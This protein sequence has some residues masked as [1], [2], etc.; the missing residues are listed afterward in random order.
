MW[1]SSF[2]GMMVPMIEVTERIISMIMVNLMDVMNDHKSLRNE[3]FKNISFHKVKILPTT[4]GT[5]KIKVSKFK[6]MAFC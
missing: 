2:W 6:T 1:G 4:E 3:F 5:E